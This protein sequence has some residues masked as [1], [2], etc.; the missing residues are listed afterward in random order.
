MSPTPPAVL[1]HGYRVLTCSRAAVPPGA[2]AEDTPPAVDCVRGCSVGGGF[3]LPDECGSPGPVVLRR[4]NRGIAGG[5]ERCPC[6][7]KR[8]L[9]VGH[10]CTVAACG[11][12]TGPQ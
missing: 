10:R 4:A 9:E 6:L 8:L 5:P 3:P 11:R 1:G 7:S 2:E 12:G